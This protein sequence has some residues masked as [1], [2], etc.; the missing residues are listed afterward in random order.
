MHV[1]YMDSLNVNRLKK[2]GIERAKCS[3]TAIYLVVAKKWTKNMPLI[4]CDNMV[5]F[6]F[7]QSSRDLLLGA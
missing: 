3:C 2:V 4:I 7:A 1:Q 6:S 5:P